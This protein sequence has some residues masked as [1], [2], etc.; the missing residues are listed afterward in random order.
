MVNS[1]NPGDGIYQVIG[2][3]EGV[4]RI[5]ERFMFHV[6]KDDTLW[7]TYFSDVDFPR[8]KGHQFRLLSQL[9]GGPRTYTA[10]NL[11]IAH[12]MI[13]RDPLTGK[14]H[15]VKQSHY[16]RVSNYILS[17]AFLEHPPRWVIRDTE[18]LLSD[19]MPVVCNMGEWASYTE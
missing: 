5:V 19:S 4:R 13:G 2:G 8:I 7:V 10:R 17:A 14:R 9:W 12:R 16:D 1:P 18:T 3:A 11:A 15:N 6:K